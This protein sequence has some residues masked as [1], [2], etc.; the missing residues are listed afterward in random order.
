MTYA[1]NVISHK[2]SEQIGNQEMNITNKNYLHFEPEA[3]K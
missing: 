1:I 2:M 3:E